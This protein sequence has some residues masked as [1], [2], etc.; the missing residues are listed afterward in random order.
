MD[1]N[2]LHG[3]QMQSLLSSL[4]IRTFIFCVH[5][6]V[7][8]RHLYSSMPQGFQSDCTNPKSPYLHDLFSRSGPTSSSFQ[9]RRS[10]LKLSSACGMYEK[11]SGRESYPFAPGS[12]PVAF[13][14]TT[15]KQMF[16]QVVI[17]PIDEEGP[18]TLSMRLT[19]FDFDP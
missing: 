18:L 15:S 10:D 19:G 4:N 14:H 12:L 16:G 17:C 13:S 9:H 1:D 2:V 8:A 7:P 11:R 5:E 6:S 3:A